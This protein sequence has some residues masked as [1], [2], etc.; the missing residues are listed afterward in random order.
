MRLAA[1]GF[2]VDY[3]DYDGSKMAEIATLNFELLRQKSA[4]F[5][6]VKVI[7]KVDKLYDVVICLE[8]IEHVG[9]PF[10]FAKDIAAYLDVEGELYISEC[11]NG[12]EDRW[13]THLLSNERYAGCLPFLMLDHFTFVTQ[14]MIPLAKP[15]V[16]RKD[17]AAKD[18]DQLINLLGNRTIF[19]Q[20]FNNKFDIGF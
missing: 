12:I 16:F 15:Y 18:A 20:L 4:M 9:D 1:A 3:M 6:N 2:S 11:F 19:S 8:V 7:R 5:D 10:D 13:P 17:N 14:N